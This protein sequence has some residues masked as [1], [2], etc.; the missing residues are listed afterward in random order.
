LS[1]AYECAV[2]RGKGEE[3]DDNRGGDVVHFNCP[4]CGRYSASGSAWAMLGHQQWTPRQVANASGWIREHQR[5]QL[6]SN[7]VEVLAS[8]RTPSVGER[9]AKVLAEIGRRWP[10]TGETIDFNFG[11]N[12]PQ[13]LPWLATSWSIDARGFNYL[14]VQFLHA[15]G[16]ITG[17]LTEEIGASILFD[18]QITPLGHEQLAKLRGG[19]TDSAI[20]F[21]AMWFSPKLLP[22]WS[23]AIEPAIRAAGYDPQRIDRVHHNNKIDDEIVAMIRRSRF[24]VADFT[25]NRGGVYFEAGFAMGR[26]IPVVWT[27]RSGR[28][29]RVHFDNRQYN[30]VDWSFDALADFKTRLQNRIE[31]TLGR[32]PL[33]KAR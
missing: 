21:C 27:I 19:G 25:G 20:G 3:K 13:L 6:S 18:A 5:I 4:R 17:H 10:E 8:L 16:L 1:G 9:A 7:D 28:F 29:H 32:G 2:C 33:V 14:L 11:A 12:D 26:E 22:V 24:V 31:A 30:F 23:D 15:Q